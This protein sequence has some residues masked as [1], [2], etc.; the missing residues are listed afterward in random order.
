MIHQIHFLS[1][2]FS[3]ALKMVEQRMP[4]MSELALSGSVRDRRRLPVMRVRRKTFAHIEFFASWPKPEFTDQ[5]RR[6]FLANVR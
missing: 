6:P 4:S 5:G 2:L 3:Q 1:R